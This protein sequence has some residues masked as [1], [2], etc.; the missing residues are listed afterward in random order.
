MTGHKI[1]FQYR[2]EYLHNYL[3]VLVSA[4]LSVDIQNAYLQRQNHCD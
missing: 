4:V 2:T 1:Q 3:E